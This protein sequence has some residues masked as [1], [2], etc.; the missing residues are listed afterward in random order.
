M[1]YKIL[2]LSS[3]EEIIG[4]VT[5]S[6][7]SYII[8]KPAAI[9]FDHNNFGMIP[10][11]PFTENHTVTFDKNLVPGIG[12][13]APELVS[14]YKRVYEPDAIIVPPKSIVIAK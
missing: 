8:E 10:F 7:S 4:N 2:K 12:I 6:E 5:E 3:G 9:V 14:E 1:T 11:M 13:P